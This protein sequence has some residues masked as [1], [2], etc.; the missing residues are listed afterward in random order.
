MDDFDDTFDADDTDHGVNGYAYGDLV[1]WA[2]VQWAI[3]HE[4]NHH[5]V[6]TIAERADLVTTDG[7]VHA[8][9]EVWDAT[10]DNMA[11]EIFETW[12]RQFPTATRFFLGAADFS[13]RYEVAGVD[14]DGD[15]VESF[16]WDVA[17]ESCNLA[18]LRGVPLI[19]SASTDDG[20]TLVENKMGQ[21]TAQADLVHYFLEASRSAALNDLLIGSW[22]E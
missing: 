2:E 21:Q 6:E 5:I 8:F 14:E 17:T 20:Q 4:M 18:M 10:H 3:V 1:S 13:W 22:S 12:M 16:S 19:F 9:L 15:L 7:E 11:T